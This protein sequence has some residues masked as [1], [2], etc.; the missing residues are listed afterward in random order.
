MLSNPD[1]Q[2]QYIEPTP[3]PGCE[4]TRNSCGWLVGWFGLNGT[5][6]TNKVISCL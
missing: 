6:N 2:N 1:I 3:S 5:F 4:R